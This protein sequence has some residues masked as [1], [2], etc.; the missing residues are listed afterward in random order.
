MDISI[1][2]KEETGRWSVRGFSPDFFLLATLRPCPYPAHAPFLASRVCLSSSPL[3][4]LA[5]SLAALSPLFSLYKRSLTGTSDPKRLVQK[6]LRKMQSDSQK[7]QDKSLIQEILAWSSCKGF[8]PQIPLFKIFEKDLL[9]S[10]WEQPSDVV[11]RKQKEYHDTDRRN[12]DLFFFFFVYFTLSSCTCNFKELT[13]SRSI[14]CFNVSI[15][16]INR[17]T[18]FC[19]NLEVTRQLENT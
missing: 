3:A 15:S 6:T 8:L 19:T 1:I 13:E 18:K 14:H 5:R 4:A 10:E 17:A 11:D 16:I 7:D 9:S 12:F 2:A